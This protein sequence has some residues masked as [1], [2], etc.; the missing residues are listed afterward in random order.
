MTLTS[1]QRLAIL[2]IT[3]TATITFL[4]SFSNFENY[5]LVISACVNFELGFNLSELQRLCQPGFNSRQAFNSRPLLEVGVNS[6]GSL[7]SFR[8]HSFVITSKQSLLVL[9]IPIAFQAITVGTG[10]EVPWFRGVHSPPSGGP[11]ALYVLP[12]QWSNIHSEGLT[13]DTE[14]RQPHPLTREATSS[15]FYQVLG[16]NMHSLPVSRGAL[17]GIQ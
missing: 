9:S 3:S 16:S 10:S 12:F 7:A 11:L 14:S 15:G 4:C 13:S 1:P 8:E 17:F 2:T 5:L 6:E